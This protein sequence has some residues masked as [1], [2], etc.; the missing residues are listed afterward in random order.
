MKYPVK[1]AAVAVIG[2]VQY[3]CAAQIP[4]IESKSSL[5]LTYASNAEGFSLRLTNTSGRVRCIDE[6]SW[7]NDLGQ[8]HMAGDILWVDLEN[9]KYAAKDH[10]LGYCV[11]KCQI[12]IESGESIAANVPFSEFGGLAEQPNFAKGRVTLL[13]QEKRCR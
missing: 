9:R 11:G 7:P 6:Q 5:D 3:G 4:S 1:M 10:N 12:R 2:L 8:T 13:L